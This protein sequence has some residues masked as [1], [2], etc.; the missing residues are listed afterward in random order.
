MSDANVV[1]GVEDLG[2]HG[3]VL[4]VRAGEGGKAPVT[5]SAGRD[6]PVEVDFVPVADA[7]DARFRAVVSA[8]IGDLPV[9][10]GD[11][12]KLTAGQAV[13]AAFVF[14]PSLSLAGQIVYL[15]VMVVREAGAEVDL[16]FPVTVAA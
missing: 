12:G 14:R 3:T 11:L 6:V 4:Q 7:G 15:R 10:D 9:A 2:G 8:P 16:Q 5:V 13:T 1:L